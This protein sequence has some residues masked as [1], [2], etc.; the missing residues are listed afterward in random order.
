MNICFICM[1]VL[2]LQSCSK[3]SSFRLSISI[4][5]IPIELNAITVLVFL[6]IDCMNL[7]HWVCR[8]SKGTSSFFVS[9]DHNSWCM[10]KSALYQLGMGQLGT[11]QLGP[12]FQY[13]IFYYGRNMVNTVNSYNW[14]IWNIYNWLRSTWT[15]FKYFLIC[16][17]IIIRV[18][19][20][21]CMS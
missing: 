12:I 11:G 3:K 10:V 15:N 4:G 8:R 19:R 9:L 6:C 5:N 1:R 2:R 17:E 13:N 18:K 20:K 14:F 16:V 7:R 21:L